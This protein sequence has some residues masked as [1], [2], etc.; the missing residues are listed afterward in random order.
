[1]AVKRAVVLPRQKNDKWVEMLEVFIVIDKK[2][3]H[4]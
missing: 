1:M 3:F 2:N 4:V